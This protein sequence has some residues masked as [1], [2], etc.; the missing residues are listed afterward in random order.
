MHGNIKQVEKGKSM[1]DF[2][3][4]NDNE[5]EERIKK[6]EKRIKKLEKK[7][8]ELEKSANTVKDNS[9]YV[10]TTEVMGPMN[11]PE[12]KHPAS[13]IASCYYLNSPLPR[14][15]KCKCQPSYYIGES[16]F[17]GKLETFVE[18]LGERLPEL[19]EDEN[20]ESIF[21]RFNRKYKTQNNLI[22]TNTDLFVY[23][24]DYMLFAKDRGFSHNDYFDYELYNKE[25]DIRETFLNEGYRLRVYAACNK[26]GFRKY[27][28]NKAKFNKKFKKYVK[29]EWI[30]CSKCEYEVFEKFVN[31]HEVFFGKPV[32]GTGGEGA[33]VIERSSMPYDKLYEM[34]KAEELIL[35]EVIKQHPSLAAFNES[36]LNTV[37]VNTLVC[38]DGEVR[39]TL[40]VA[41]FGRAGN[42]V[43]NFHGGG[44][45]AIVDIDSGVLITN[46]I[47]R[48]HEKTDVHPDSQKQVLGFK[49]PEWDKVKKAVTEAALMN[50]NARHVGW[51]VTVTNKGTV[52][53]VEGNSRPNFDVLQSPDQLGRRFRYAPYIPEIEK[54]EGIEYVLEPLKELD[55]TGMETED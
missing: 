29:R 5:L 52:E 47:N 16:T 14:H 28:S 2:L 38:A 55:I 54:L 46:A 20:L 10:E 27:Y 40:A 25:L 13:I 49:Y 4:K 33:R 35:E 34:C 7:Y 12:D 50:P 18:I 32:R 31:K 42:A 41:R 17:D 39:V 9:T 21:K 45:G 19:G 11:G 1:F 48:V 6:L 37:R 43:D 44:V 51:D 26:P 23:F 22:H 30:D 15:A 8:A 3:K 24:C 53:F 36:T